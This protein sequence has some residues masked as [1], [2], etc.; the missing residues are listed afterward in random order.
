[1]S[2]FDTQTGLHGKKTA[3][4]PPMN[5][6]PGELRLWRKLNGLLNDD[7]KK[8]DDLEHNK[9]KSRANLK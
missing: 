1:M 5:A 6:S 3:T 2:G 4:P 9:A 8:I 7:E